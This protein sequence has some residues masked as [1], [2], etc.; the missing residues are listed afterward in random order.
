MFRAFV[1]DD[2]HHYA[3]AAKAFCVSSSVD[4]VGFD[5]TPLPAWTPIAIKVGISVLRIFL[6]MLAPAGIVEVNAI[7]TFVILMLK[8]GEELVDA[9]L[10]RPIAVHPGERGQNDQ[11]HDR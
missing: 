2:F 3:S 6:L 1:D 7:G 4:A 8:G 5:Q 11:C 10:F 9:V